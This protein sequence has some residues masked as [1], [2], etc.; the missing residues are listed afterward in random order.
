[1]IEIH[2]EG[3]ASW[4]FDTTYAKFVG[5]KSAPF[6]EHI[7]IPL[8][9]E[10]GDYHF[11][12]IVT[13]KNGNQTMVESELEIQ[14]PTDLVAPQL[15]VAVA[16]ANGQNYS[17]GEAIIISGSIT[18]NLSLGGIYIGLV[19]DDQNLADSEVNAD[20]TITLLHFHDFITPTSYSFTGS[21]TVGSAMDNDV[22]PDP[23]TWTPG[24]YYLLVKCKDSFG[25]NW[26]FSSHYPVVIN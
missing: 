9:A 18:D 25:G 15:S 3:N 23:I 19:R 6:H 8:T 26:T 14:Q 17:S 11:H 16:P 1:M 13:D 2:P 12:L 22:T 20:N 7:D 24:S 10:P 4:G 21:I 5:L